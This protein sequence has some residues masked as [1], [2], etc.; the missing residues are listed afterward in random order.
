VKFNP[1][2]SLKRVFLKTRKTK[3]ITSGAGFI[4][5]IQLEGFGLA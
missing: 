3:E 4:L 2:E 5:A 1:K